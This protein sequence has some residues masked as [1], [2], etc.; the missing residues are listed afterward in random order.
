MGCGSTPQR[1]T[2]SIHRGIAVPEQRADLLPVMDLK[3]TG[4]EVRL[5]SHVSS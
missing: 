1:S 5:L 3:L 4:G 2:A